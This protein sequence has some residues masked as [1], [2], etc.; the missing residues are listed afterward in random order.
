MTRQNRK[1]RSFERAGAVASLL[2]LGASLLF[3]ISIDG[4]PP[5]HRASEIR[6]MD[7]FAQNYAGADWSLVTSDLAAH[8]D[9]PANPAF[10]SVPLS[11]ANVYLNRYETGRDKADL[12]RS[13]QTVEWVTSHRGLWGTREGSGS[14]VSYVDISVLRL[15]AEC[16]IGGFETRI[17]DLWRTAMAI[18]AEEAGALVGTPERPC[19]PSLRLEA[20]VAS[21]LPV[22]A[23]DE[24]RASRAA[25]FAAAASFLPGDPRA[26]LWAD[27]ARQ[28]ALSLPAYVCP[29]ADTE[30]ALSQ[31]TLSYQLAGGDAPPEFGSQGGGNSGDTTLRCSPFPTRYETAGAVA[32]VEPGPALAVA[33]RDSQLVAFSLSEVYLVRFPPGSGCDG[34]DGAG[35][36]LPRQQS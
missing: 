14:V 34:Y 10:M 18:T 5:R 2:F 25:L 1:I 20:C 24:S 33:I 22:P 15:Q 17:A 26:P 30:L 35:D 7:I 16:D 3:A 4:R 23:E 8:P 9:D 12:E 28:L 32:I 19:R 6:W 29:T 13:I 31:A 21:I 36:T 27:G 11:L